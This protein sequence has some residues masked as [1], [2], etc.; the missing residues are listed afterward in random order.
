MPPAAPSVAELLAALGAVFRRLGVRWYVFGAQA[1]A[2]RGLPRST[3]DVDVTVL[4]MTEPN[5]VLVEALA[6]GGFHVPATRPGF[7]DATRVLPVVHR[8]TRLPVDIVLGGSGLEE[9]FAE[10]AE[11]VRVGRTVVP[12]A[13]ISD[14]V[15]MK[16]IAGRPK[17]LEDARALLAT[18]RV[19]TATVRQVLEAFCDAVGEGDA[20]ERWTALQPPA[21]RAG[22][23]TARTRPGRQRR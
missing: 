17:D 19:E 2:I 7:V 10:R 22:A 5:Q 21:R 6:R 3:A 9:L 13:S 18:G 23:R 14:L 16:M 20:L 4:W 15:V 11:K 8:G 12:V 1:L